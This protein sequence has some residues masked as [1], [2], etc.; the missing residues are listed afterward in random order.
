MKALFDLGNVVLNWD[1]LT[2]VRSLQLSD[3]EKNLIMD[4]LFGHGD[5]LDFDKGLVTE[6]KLLGRVAK[7]SGIS[8]SDLQHC[9]L[10]TKKSLTDIE[11][12]V[13][14]MQELHLS[15]I[16]MYCLSNMPV[17]TFEFVKNR[18]LFKYFSGVVISGSIKMI[19]PEMEIFTYT[20]DKLRLS[21]EST[22]F[23]DDSLANILAAKKVGIN[24]VLFKR[25]DHCYQKIRRIL[26]L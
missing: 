21:A 25:T 20:L 26:E 14:L 7:R 3:K 24:G 5:W 17:E 2:V 11:K 1:P 16:E 13:D 4:H 18:P 22:L 19:K 9:L 8:L 10:Q 12:T 23:I 6:E 15:G